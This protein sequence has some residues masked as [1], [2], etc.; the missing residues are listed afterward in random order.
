MEPTPQET[1]LGNKITDAI[2]TA[3][4][5]AGGSLHWPE[6]TTVVVQTLADNRP[7]VA[8]APVVVTAEMIYA[9]YPRKVAPKLAVKSILKAAIDVNAN[10]NPAA[11]SGALPFL[12][13]KTKA[14]AEAVKR[15]PKEDQDRYCPHP[16]TWFNRGSYLDDPKEWE[17]GTGPK[18]KT[19]VNYSQI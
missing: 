11:T 16:S 17:R 8:A 18:A 19:P 5:A 15:W 10:G 13:E 2:R 1:E 14:Y 9:T 3:R 12:L 7:L 4:K 6:L